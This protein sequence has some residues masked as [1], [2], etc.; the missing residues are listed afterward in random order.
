MKATLSRRRHWLGRLGSTAAM[1]V[2]AA[3]LTTTAGAVGA[4]GKAAWRA[5]ARHAHFAVYRPRRTLGLVFD[6]VHLTPTTGCLVANW[7]NPRSAKGP[8]LGLSEPGDTSRCGQPGVATKVA[9]TVINHVKV[10]VLVQCPTWPRCGIKNGSTNGA[11]L[12]FVPEHV[13]K[14]YTIQLGSSHVG[15]ARFLEVAHSFAR[16]R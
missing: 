13:A 14:R 6:G 12:L 9:T 8:H 3:T 5:V 1:V 2:V 4:S 10:P 7:G 15:L 16:V 11:F